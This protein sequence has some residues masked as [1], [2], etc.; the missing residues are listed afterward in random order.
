[1]YCYFSTHLDT[2][3]FAAHH[4]LIDLVDPDSLIGKSGRSVA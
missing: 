4:L 3:A 2:S 1:L